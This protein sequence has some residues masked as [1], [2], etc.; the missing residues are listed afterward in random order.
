MNF[1]E[2]SHLSHWLL[3]LSQT[4]RSSVLE[5]IFLHHVCF[6]S[7]HSPIHFKIIKSSDIFLNWVIW[8]FGASFSGK[9]VLVLF[10]LIVLFFLFFST[11]SFL[12]EF[13]KRKRIRPRWFCW[14]E[15]LRSRIVIGDFGYFLKQIL[16]GIVEVV[17]NLWLS[18]TFIRVVLL[19]ICANTV[20][21][22]ITHFFFFIVIFIHR[23]IVKTILLLFPFHNT[24]LLLPFVS[25]N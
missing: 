16:D 18:G 15:W 11:Y 12:F 21:I 3:N 25:I 1:F 5:A 8:R 13:A 10:I 4:M 22:P 24:I 7:L 9:R 2:R 14:I 19:L 23:N 17:N 20:K 6:C